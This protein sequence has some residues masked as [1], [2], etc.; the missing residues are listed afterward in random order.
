MVAIPMAL[1]PTAKQIYTWR[2]GQKRL[3]EF[4]KT[5]Y[6]KCGYEDV[7]AAAKP[8]FEHAIAS[9]SQLGPFEEE[10]D[11]LTILEQCVLELNKIQY[12]D[13]IKNSIMTVEREIY[14]NIVLQ[15]GDFVG[16]DFQQLLDETRGF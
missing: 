3:V 1:Y 5:D 6:L 7:N 10:K 4:S 8:V 14:C 2:T 9:L 11:K 12:D 16:V 13:T 15:F